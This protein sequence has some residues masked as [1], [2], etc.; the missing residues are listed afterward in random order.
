MS[1]KATRND[2]LIAQ[3]HCLDSID[4][5]RSTTSVKEWLNRHTDLYKKVT[6]AP[7]GLPAIV[8]SHFEAEYFEGIQKFGHLYNTVKTIF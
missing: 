1:I 7:A 4:D 3:Q 2:Y 5:F 8:D 6:I